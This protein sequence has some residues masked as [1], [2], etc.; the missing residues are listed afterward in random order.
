M[1]T[2]IQRRIRKDLV[3]RENFNKNEYNWML[4]KYNMSLY[5]LDYKFKNWVFLKYMRRF[6][7]NSSM[8]RINSICLLSGRAHWVLRKFRVSRMT[9]HQLADFGQIIGVRRSSW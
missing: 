1:Y 8:S 2:S 4:M 6:H 7:L 5:F 9:F 3:V